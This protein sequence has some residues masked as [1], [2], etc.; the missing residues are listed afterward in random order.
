MLS[1]SL[2]L[3]STTGFAG[4][5]SAQGA[6]A[7]AGR[8]FSFELLTQA[9][10]AKAAEPYATV[11]VELPAF[12]QDLDYDKYRLVQFD[13]KRAK[14]ADAGLPYHVHAFH[15]GWLFKEPVELFKVEGDNARPMGFTTEDFIYYNELKDAEKPLEMPGVAGFRLNY[16]LN[17]P[18]TFDEVVSFLGAS[19]F[20]ALGQNNVYG[21]SARG[22]VLNSWVDEPEE[23]PRFSQFYL[24][25]PG[26][27]GPIT[28]YAALEG[29]SVT[30]AYRFVIAPGAATTMEVTA[31]LFFRNAVKELGIAPLTS[32]FLY[33][34][35]NRS[36]FDDYRPQVHDS[37]GL[38]VERSNGE[39]LWRALNNPPSLANSYIEDD[40]P[41]SFGLHQ[42]TREFEHYQDANARY[43]R[44]PSLNVEPIGDWGRGH[45]RLVEIPSKLEAEDNI[46]AFWV[47]ADA[48]KPGDEREYAY[49][50]SWGD[51][52][53]DPAG[54]VG[55]VY[56]TRAGRGGVSGTET[57]ET[58]RKFVIDFK[59]HEL[60]SIDAETK[61][62]V[63]AAVSGGVL[64]FSTVS[65]IPEEGIW[66][67]VLDVEV[68]GKDPV[69]LRAYLVGSGRILTET[70]LYQW[71]A[72][73]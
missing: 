13:P 73:A 71:R 19:Y 64:V 41:H 56:D 34:D 60:E 12:M 50:L 61:L 5:A 7:D 36:Q 30:G 47:P 21:L 29:K 63:F 6:P 62:D 44:R 9:M 57:A 17:R 68:V 37:N 26:G 48:P 27:E 51:L 59:G 32:M 52:P 3:F 49:K 43:E 66:R 38:A 46:V 54:P 33:A 40:S 8:P 67:A 58:L 2:A 42:R 11:Q 72:S 28:V 23:F 39:R 69:E 45:L 10:R 14:W 15:L 18:G 20:R 4:L 1:A 22:I 65:K 25:R 16:P 70:W 35:N 55:Y 53:P 24:Q 31:R